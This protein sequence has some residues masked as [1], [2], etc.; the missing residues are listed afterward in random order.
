MAPWEGVNALDAA[1]TAYN[2]ISVMRQEMLPSDRAHAIIV[3]PE[4]APVNIIPAYCQLKAAVRV[5][6]LPF[7]RRAS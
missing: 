7:H 4:G 2:S 1:V 6:A 3:M 5:S